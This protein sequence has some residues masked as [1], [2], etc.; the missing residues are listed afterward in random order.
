[1]DLNHINLPASV[2]ADL[3]H[4][5]LI[6]PDTQQEQVQAETFIP[7][8]Q[9]P[10]VDTYT[11]EIKWL[12]EN[13]KNILIVLK[14][15]DAVHIPDEELNFLTG[16]LGACKL[17]IADVALLNLNNNA[18]LSYA[19]IQSKLKSKIIFLFGI[20][21]TEFGLPINFPHFQIQS[22]SNSTF[23]F[24]PVLKEL[25]SDKVLKSKLWVCLK[26]IFSL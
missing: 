15:T 18:G 24:S 12:G 25:E 16:I 9:S 13:R 11:N 26:K 22:F 17:S 5:I 6:E 1:M 2:I 19:Q 8:K 23:L 10:Q 20:E 3:Y 14:Y 21:P 4:S 7:Q